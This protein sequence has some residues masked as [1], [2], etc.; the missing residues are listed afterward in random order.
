MQIHRPKPVEAYTV[1]ELDK[2]Y[3][4]LLEQI[5]ILPNSSMSFPGRLYPSLIPLKVLMVPGI[6]VQHKCTP[7]GI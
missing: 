6:L 2:V 1:Q 5:V 7:I 3:Q 4:A